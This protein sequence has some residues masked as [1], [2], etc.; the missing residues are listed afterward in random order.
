M[1]D[2]DSYIFNNYV[3][4]FIDILGQQDELDGCGL[5]PVFDSDEDRKAFISVARESVGAIQELHNNFNTFFDSFYDTQ[6]EYK[7]PPELEKDYKAIKKTEVKFQ[8]FSDGLVAYI[9][10]SEDSGSLPVN[11]LYSLIVA[12]GSLCFIGLTSK[13][14][15][16]AGVDLAWGIELNENELYGCVVSKAYNLESKVAQYP[17]VVIGSEVVQYLN[18]LAKEQGD[19]L[20]T[21]YNR[22]MAN[23]CLSMLCTDP[24]GQ[25]IVN[26]L[27][28]YFRENIAE[29]I[30]NN[31]FDD[32]YSYIECQEN[33]YKEQNNTKL[34]SRYRHLKSYYD[35]HKSKWKNDV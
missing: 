17:R 7:L 19:N 35:F 4:A 31:T 10:F 25:Y 24:D 29:N 6:Q 13:K 9:S 5:L 2:N 22:V 14:P 32:A 20:H 11:G 15:I 8:R 33:I 18:Y 16:R 30:D 28:D 34:L 27:G 23:T 1:Q 3:A 12:C 21:K 26:Y